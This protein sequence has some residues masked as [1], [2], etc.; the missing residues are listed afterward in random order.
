M[1]VHSLEESTQDATFN[2]YACSVP[3]GGAGGSGLVEEAGKLRRPVVE[4]VG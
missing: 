4:G 3:T 2:S 1:K